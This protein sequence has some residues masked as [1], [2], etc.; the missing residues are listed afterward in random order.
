MKKIIL[1]TSI[2]LLAF[3]SQAEDIPNKIA[4]TASDFI[5]NLIPGEG[6]TEVSID[7][8]ENY[9]P[10]FSILGVREI[11]KNSNNNTFMQFS[12]SNT[13]KLNK[14]RYVGN[15]GMGKRFLSD[16]SHTL[17]GLNIF[18]DYDHYGNTRGSIGG[19]IKS[20][21]MGLTS[22]YYKKIDNGSVDEEVL[23]GY[24]IELTSQIPYLHWADIF[25]NNYKWNGAEREDLEGSKIGTEMLLTP[26]L[27]F[28]AAYDDKDKKGLEDEYYANI[29][30]VHP[31]RE[32][33]T[34][35]D[36]VSNQIWKK[37]KDMSD[38]M[39]AKVK[40][41]NKIMIEFSGSTVISRAD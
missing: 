11:E 7:L 32:G 25:Y 38:E 22:N 36:G 13:E 27:A 10:D 1:I 14:E 21:V 8:R 28:E 3:N 20:A 39:I 18:L 6:T 24:D 33:A 12:L 4:N 15:L 40:R 41:N 29:I 37:E 9:K 31:P 16:D 30:F 35:Q 17:T 26:N 23:D 34:A 19:E 2:L 5:S